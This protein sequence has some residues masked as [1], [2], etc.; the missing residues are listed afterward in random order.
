[1]ADDDDTRDGRGCTLAFVLALLL[2]WLPILLI[3]SLVR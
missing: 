2:V 1:M 3:W